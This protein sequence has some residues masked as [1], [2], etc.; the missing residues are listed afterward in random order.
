MFTNVALVAASFCL[1]ANAHLFMSSP[2]PIEGTAP[3]DP[4]D[5]SGS[6]FPCHGVALTG[7]GGQSMA[8][9][10][11]QLLKWDAGQTDPTVGGLNTAVHGGGSCQ[12]SVTYETDAEKV[13]DPSNWKVIYSIEEGCPTNSPLN[14]DSSY[15]GPNGTYSAAW[16]CSDEGTNGYDCL[17][18][19]DFNIPKGLKNG[20]ATLAWTWFN[21]VGNREMYMNCAAIDITGGSDDDSGMSAFPN[22]F[23]ANL[24]SVNTCQST[25]YTNVKFP[26][27][28]QYGIQHTATSRVAVSSPTLSYPLAVPSGCGSV[29]D[30][31]SASSTSTPTS[32]YAASLSVGL[33]LTLSLEQNGKTSAAV[34]AD[35]TATVQSTT[36][37]TQTG[38]APSSAVATSIPTSAASSYAAPAASAAATGVSSSGSNGTCDGGKISCPTPGAIICVGQSQFGL[39]NIDYCAIPQALASGTTCASGVISKRDVVRRGSRVHRHVAGHAHKQSL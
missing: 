36:L 15:T 21:N 26:D 16:Q 13:K 20:Q 37:L 18:Q 39:C 35:E 9:G 30:S 5:A 8:V 24:E 11:K 1:A 28:G 29:V 22:L 2:S 38:Y 27:P 25:A 19:F 14:L 17:N 34:A 7:S 12:L 23:V 6:N 10:S 31:G 4:L 3:K 32:T 33:G